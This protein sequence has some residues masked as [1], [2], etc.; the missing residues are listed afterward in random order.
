MTGDGRTISRQDH[1]RS[2]NATVPPAPGQSGHASARRPSR[3]PRRPALTRR[4]R[5]APSGRPPDHPGG[6]VAGSASATR[7]H[8]DEGVR[9]CLFRPAGCWLLTGRGLS[10]TVLYCLDRPRR[11]HQEPGRPPPGNPQDAEHRQQPGQ[12]PARRHPSGVTTAPSQWAVPPGR[13]PE[14]AARRPSTDGAT[15]QQSSHRILFTRLHETREVSWRLLSAVD[16]R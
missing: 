13:R 5:P 9:R 12:A 15:D 3:E 7:T 4:Q 8:A 1:Q 10:A 14:S 16:A 11:R 6:P 2:P